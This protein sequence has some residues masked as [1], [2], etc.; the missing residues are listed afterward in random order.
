MTINATHDTQRAIDILTK[1]D[2]DLHEC[3]AE[4]ICDKYGLVL[5]GSIEDEGYYYLERFP[6]LN[7]GVISDAIAEHSYQN[8]WCGR[9]ALAYG[10]LEDYLSEIQA[11]K[12]AE[13]KATDD[14][15]SEY[16][17]E[18]TRELE[19]LESDGLLEFSVFESRISESVYFEITGN[20]D[21]QEEVS[22]R[23]SQHNNNKQR[24]ST[25]NIVF[26]GV[27]KYDPKELIDD[28]TS[29]LKI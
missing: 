27:N 6:T 17:T 9:F 18:V 21:E 23:I 8:P 14:E 22:V 1:I 28:I 4:R 10:P 11:I 29:K 26:D 7:R 24:K 15:M 2:L 12:E 13:E 16:V 5:Y 3:I 19:R 20:G 25:F